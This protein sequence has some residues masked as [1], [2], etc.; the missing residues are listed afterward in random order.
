MTRIDEL[1]KRYPIIPRDVILKHDVMVQGVRDGEDMDKI[2][3]WSPGEH[4][5][6]SN[7]YDVTLQDMA[8][9]APWRVKGGLLLRP[10]EMRF[11]SGLGAQTRLRS[12]SPYEIRELSD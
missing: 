3:S 1:Q 2:S 11:K 4:R 12:T 8:R 6:Q 7:H 10:D 9:K 5:Y